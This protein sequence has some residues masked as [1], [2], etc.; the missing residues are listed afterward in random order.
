MKVDLERQRERKRDVMF[1]PILRNLAGESRLIV[2]IRAS[3]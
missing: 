3:S 1:E 2:T